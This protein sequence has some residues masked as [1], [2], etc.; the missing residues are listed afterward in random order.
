MLPNPAVYFLCTSCSYLLLPYMCNLYWSLP[1]PSSHFLSTSSPHSS[2]SRHFLF[3]M[4]T[5]FWDCSHFVMSCFKTIVS[6]SLVHFLFLLFIPCPL[7]FFTHFLFLWLSISC[8]PRNDI[9][10]LVILCSCSWPAVHFLSLS[11]PCHSLFV[12]YI[13]CG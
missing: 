11:L 10:I 12:D 7:P 9:D 3:I 6:S 5:S 13:C 2:L 8:S 4:F 1:A